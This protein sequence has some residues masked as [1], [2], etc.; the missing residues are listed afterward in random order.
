MDDALAD[1]H[2][3]NHPPHVCCMGHCEQCDTACTAWLPSMQV[4]SEVNPEDAAEASR[5]L[6]QSLAPWPGSET[7]LLPSVR[8]CCCAGSH[9]CVMHQHAICA[10]PCDQQGW[11]AFDHRFDLSHRHQ[12][13]GFDVCGCVVHR[14][15]SCWH[16]YPRTQSAPCSLL[17]DAMK[18]SFNAWRVP[19]LLKLMITISCCPQNPTVQ[20]PAWTEAGV[21]QDTPTLLNRDQAAAAQP[22]P[23]APP[24]PTA[25]NANA[26]N[27]ACC[28]LLAAMGFR[29]NVPV[30]VVDTQGRVVPIRHDVPAH[31]CTCGAP[32]GTD[33]SGWGEIKVR[34]SSS[35]VQMV[36]KQFGLTLRQLVEGAAASNVTGAEVAG[37]QQPLVRAAAGSMEAAGQMGPSAAVELG[38]K[39]AAPFL[40]ACAMRY[41]CYY[42]C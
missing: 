29:S 33:F 17:L 11:S 1:L 38:K 12:L 14:P 39:Q 31:V 28:A 37:G 2:M 35:A 9:A 27:S 30:V 8:L 34:G 24:A 23:S 40:G 41:C 5:T 4:V 7:I 26:S 42:C 20:V 3:P 6:A 22:I 32:N 21:Q 15:R 25:P 13:M 18:R 10:V 16:L 19:C 36:K